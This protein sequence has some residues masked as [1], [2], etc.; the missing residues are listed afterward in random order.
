M[1]VIKHRRLQEFHVPN[2]TKAV[3]PH[4]RLNLAGSGLCLPPSGTPSDCWPSANIRVEHG[5]R[6]AERTAPRNTRVADEAH[7]RVVA[8]VHVQDNAELA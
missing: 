7:V 5:Q 3:L 6:E 4:A 8:A 1:M 2:F